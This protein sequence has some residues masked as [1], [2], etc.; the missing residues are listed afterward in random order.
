MLSLQLQSAAAAFLLALD[1][2]KHCQQQ[3][4]WSARLNRKV[5]KQQDDQVWTAAAFQAVC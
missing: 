2:L 1:N 3:A 5:W 4:S